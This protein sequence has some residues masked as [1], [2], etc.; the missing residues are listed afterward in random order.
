MTGVAA[1]VA[2]ARRGGQTLLIERYGCLGGM[3][4]V[5]LVNPWMFHYAW[6]CFDEPGREVI[7]GIYQEILERLEWQGAVAK[8]KD[9]FPGNRAFDAETLK[10]TL[11]ELCLESGVALRFHTWVNGL[12]KSGRAIEALT[13]TSKSGPER[14]ASKIFVDATGDADVAASGGC[15]TVFGREE[16]GKAQAMTLMFRLTD[17]EPEAE[18][19][20]TIFL[21]AVE[22]GRLKLPGKTHGLLAF[23][24][25][26]RAVLTFN[27]NEVV[28]RCGVDAA[29]LTE[30]EIEGRRA[31]R[32]LVE[33]L[34]A[35]VPGFAAC[36]VE[37]TGHHIG[38]RET[39]RIVGQYVLTV[40]DLLRCR[41]FEDTVACGAY[42]VDIHDPEGK[43]KIPMQ[44]LKTGEYYD[45]PYRSLLPVEVDNLLVA[46]RCLSATHEAAAAVRVMPICTAMG[47]AAGEAAA[48]SVRQ[49]CSPTRLDSSHLRRNLLESGAFLGTGL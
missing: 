10:W 3:A 33:F 41:R 29:Q 22:S 37:A 14:F 38:V 42:P 6:H 28:G 40:D 5:G 12:E 32:E 21:K 34:R 36:R 18:I 13:T 27:Q 30:A 26:G 11:D 8:G 35:D 23:R 7:A 1:A 48:L 9:V 45:L 15:G 31:I 44:G 19:D 17:F 16:D 25:P 49:G 20:R 46:G 39:R 4:T 47:Q 43:A 2:A 24:Y